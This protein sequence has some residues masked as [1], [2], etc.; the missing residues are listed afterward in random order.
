M[1]FSFSRVLILYGLHIPS[2]Q[3]DAQNRRSWAGKK[4]LTTMALKPQPHISCLFLSHLQITLLHLC[5]KSLSHTVTFF[6]LLYQPKLVKA[7]DGESMLFISISI[8]THLC[9]KSLFNLL[10]IYKSLLPVRSLHR[11]R[12]RRKSLDSSAPSQVTA[13]T[14]SAPQTFF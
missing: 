8:S 2:W 13:F 4:L 1:L 5:G 9:I 12:R 11:D 10:S 14:V 6:L 3:T 7:S